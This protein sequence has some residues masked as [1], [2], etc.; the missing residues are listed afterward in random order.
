MKYTEKVMDHF[1]NPRNV[2]SIEDADGVGEVGNPACGDIMTFTIKVS[3]GKL[4]DVRF[5]TFGCGAAIAVSSMISE[6]AMGKSLEEA[7]RIKNRDVAEALDGLPTNKLHCS[8]LGA[9]ALHAAIRDYYARNGTAKEESVSGVR[10]GTK[11]RKKEK[12]SCK[13]PYCDVETPADSPICKGCGSALD[14]SQT[15]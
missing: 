7:L 6:M 12:G 3:G 1:A 14:E 10:R 5:Q 8:N 15:G 2:G 13:C 4:Q 11:G 9:E